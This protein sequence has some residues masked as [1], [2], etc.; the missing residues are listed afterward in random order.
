MR[1]RSLNLLIAVTF[2]ALLPLHAQDL[3][4][5]LPKR[6]KPTP[7]QKLNQDG[8][9]A[10]NKH[11][12]KKAERL[13]YKAYLID[14]DDPFTLNN[15]GYISELQGNVERALRYYQLAARQDSQTIIADSSVKNLKG[16]PLTAVTTNFGDRD[17]RINRAN[18]EAMSLLHQG[19]AVEA[20]DELR[21]T[22][23]IDPRNAF[24][25][26][27]LGYTME[28]EGD[29]NSAYHFYTEAANQNSD[30]KIIVAAD[31]K[32]RGHGISDIAERNARAVDQR[33]KTEDSVEAKVARLNLEGV[34][35]LN[36]NDP[37][38][39]R[40]F[41]EQAYKLDPHNAFA[42][43]NMGYVSEMEGDQ[44]TAQELYQEARRAPGADDKVTV[45]SR[46]EMQGMALGAVAQVNDQATDAELEQQR[47]ARR[48]EGGP[49]ELR[50]RDNTLVTE[51]ET[52]SPVQQA[53]QPTPEPPPVTG[54]PQVPP[55]QSAPVLTPRPESTSPQ[56]APTTQ[57]PQTQPPPQ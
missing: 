6:S 54:S 30:E 53:P 44:E 13:F 43:N 41:F 12:I 47:E 5:T 3:H 24:T 14:P 48:R 45:A 22:L 17:L 37:Q 36:H 1:V 56:A 16:K 11:D 21:Q 57:T 31:P 27:N 38:K 2:A 46:R 35:A 7:V 32:W 18:I 26:N 9:K 15:L 19:R 25:L 42:L 34:S 10:I 50:R 40:G 33:I 20:E 52:P 28:A 39:A 49:I 4:I 51:P 8:V 29:L 23:Q 55:P